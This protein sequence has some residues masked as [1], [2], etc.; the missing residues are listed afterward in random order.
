MGV[1][2][3]AVGETGMLMDAR[4]LVV[5]EASMDILTSDGV[6]GMLVGVVRP[7]E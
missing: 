2:R 4:K 7:N 1:L 5:G 3:L 6:V